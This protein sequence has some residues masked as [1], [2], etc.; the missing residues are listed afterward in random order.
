MNKKKKRIKI[1]HWRNKNYNEKLKN[2]K[3]IKIEINKK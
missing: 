3:L 1:I 2:K